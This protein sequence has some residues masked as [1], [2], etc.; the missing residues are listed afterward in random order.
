MKKLATLCLLLTCLQLLHAQ[1]PYIEWSK[2]YGATGGDY[3]DAIKVTADGGFIA[4]GGIENGGGDVKGYHGVPL[5]GDIWV[6]KLSSAGVLQ[7][8][9]CLNGDYFDRGE[10]VVQTADGGY[11]VLCSSASVNC[12]VTDNRGRSLDIVLIKLSAAGD[13]EW[14]KSLGGTQ[15]EY[16]ESIDMT[17]DGGYIIG[18]YSW[19]S[20]ID[21]TVNKGETDYWVLKV[22]GRGNV[23]WQNSGGGSGDEA[24]LSVRATPDGGAVA[25]GSEWSKDGDFT[26]NYGY[27]DAWAAKYDKNGALQW[28]KNY[29]SSAGDVGSSIQCTPDGGYIM[30]GT[31]GAPDHDVTSTHGIPNFGDY[32]LVKLNSDGSIAWQ[33]TYGGSKNENAANVQLTADGGYILT[34]SAE[35]ADGDLSCNAGVTDVWVVKV[36]GAGNLQWSKSMGGNIYDQG[37]SIKPINSTEYIVAAY[38][39]S[40]NVTGHRSPENSF[41]TC[42]DFWI[43]KLSAPAAIMPNPRVIINSLSASICPGVN[44]L[45]ATVLNAGETYAFNWQKNG[46]PAGTDLT[47]TA[48]DFKEGDI[49]TCTITT[50]GVCN[51]PAVQASNSITITGK[52]ARAVPAISLVANNTALCGCTKVLATAT[53]TSAGPGSVYSWYV[54]NAVVDNDKATYAVNTLNPGDKLQCVYNDTLNCIPGDSVRSNI[55]TF[56]GATNVRPQVAI[57]LSVTGVICP[58]MPVKFIATPGNAGIQPSYQWQ[59]NGVATGSNADT[60]VIKT[61]KDGDVVKCYLTTDP[62]FTC[63]IQN[64]ATSNSITVN[65]PGS[66]TPSVQISIPSASICVGTQATFTA[67]P[68]N[69]GAVPTYQWLVNGSAIPSADKSIFT[70]ST[71]R[72]GDI[73]SCNMFVDAGYTCALQRQATS[74]NI[75][76]TVVDKVPPT[77]TISAP[78]QVICAGSPIAFTATVTN[79]GA[80]PLYQWLVNNIQVGNNN[81]VYTTTAL[82]KND[83]VAC[84]LTATNAACPGASVQSNVLRI[85]VNDAPVITLSP[86][87]TIVTTGAVIKLSTVVQGSVSSFTWQPADKLADASLLS[88]VTTALT[89][90]ALFKLSVANSDGCSATKTA[91][92]KVYSLFLMPNAFTPNNDNTNDVFRIPPHTPIVLN[93]FSVYNR[94]GQLIFFTKD[95]NLGWDGTIKGY[96][97]PGGVYVYVVHAKNNTGKD[98][99]VKGSV[100][101]IR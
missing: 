1:S 46:V 61:L 80:S 49:I 40:N 73:V 71:P 17:A 77:V 58:G 81:A 75:S 55:I 12:D 23:I 26:N 3:V 31:A 66:V 88:P 59:V 63:A 78:G 34:G 42:A 93:S 51:G 99:S 94:W 72:D 15:N 27:T 11:M 98:V 92:V 38:T 18:G 29:G 79:A 69:A 5:I 83:S 64:K 87:D 14:Q 86:A 52:K 82:Q 91:S 37:S 54:N 84:V 7:W 43:T 53:V 48:P 35:S 16:A 96:P 6:I 90:D 8:Q 32:W 101:L 4:V 47:Y 41:F 85:K 30:A 100:V 24:A 45:S 60:L 56:T 44:T 62:S 36:D 19:S 25:T 97:A 95:V 22:D 13:V 28:R 21:L 2:C 70:F 33:K 89:D 20:D 76:V 57:A 65:M 68:A 39:C 50:G 10:D 67:T 74:N 9:K